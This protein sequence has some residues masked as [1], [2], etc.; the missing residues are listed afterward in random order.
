V[1][2]VVIPTRNRPKNLTAVLKQIA[3]QSW[4]VDEV[5][6]IDS[7]DIVIPIPINPEWKFTL[8]HQSTDIKSA[9]H[10]RNLGMEIVSKRCEYLCFL[11]DDV[12]PGPQ[13]LSKL[14]GSLKKT[15]GIGISGIAMNPITHIHPRL[16]PAGIFGAIQKFFKL[17]SDTDGVLL[18]SGVNIPIRSHAG[19][20]EEVEWLIGCSVWQF[21]KIRSLRFESDFMG[22]SLCEDVIYSFRASKLGKLFVDP[23]VHLI[24]LESE[25]GRPVG[26]EFWEM[27]VV[28]RKR[29]VE[30]ANAGKRLQLHYH[31]ANIGQF[32]T[33]LY[34]GVFLR[35]T[36][37]FAAVGIILGYRKLLKGWLGL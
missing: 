17:D 3:E 2:S 31:L 16:K 13:Y 19:E 12:L 35:K 11:D 5:I 37:K 14:I 8:E 26:T 28:N 7:S 21:Q 4:P 22:Q 23:K 15:G 25:I 34:T 6:V 36:S 32:M 1:I 9:A 29:L 18:K 24:H 33:L 20:T 10:Q 30:I 27:W